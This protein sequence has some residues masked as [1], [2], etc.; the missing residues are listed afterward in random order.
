M[1]QAAALASIIIIGVA[2]GSSDVARASYGARPAEAYPFVF[3]RG[4]LSLAFHDGRGPYVIVEG[5]K[6]YFQKVNGKQVVIFEG[7]AYPV[8]YDY[9]YLFLGK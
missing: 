4:A 7:V 2:A 3:V 8:R 1:L 9:R 6:V 5:G